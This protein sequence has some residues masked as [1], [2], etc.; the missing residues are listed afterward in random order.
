MII[1]LSF[2]ISCRFKISEKIIK[3]LYNIFPDFSAF[4]LILIRSL[5][6]ERY[7]IN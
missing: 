5:V 2:H 6:G 3:S 7:Q 1:S 4:F